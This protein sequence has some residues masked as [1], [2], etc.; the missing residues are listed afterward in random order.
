MKVPGHVDMTRDAV[1][2]TA[3]ERA[4]EVEQ[5]IADAAREGIVIGMEWLVERRLET[6]IRTLL[7]GEDERALLELAYQE[8]ALESLTDVLPEARAAARRARLLQP[9]TESAP[10]AGNGRG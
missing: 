10:L 3:A 8:L 4:Q 7:P 2:L 1:L 6:L 5:L 9:V